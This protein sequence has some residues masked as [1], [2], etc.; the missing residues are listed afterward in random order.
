MGNCGIILCKEFC[1]LRDAYT[2]KREWFVTIVRRILLLCMVLAGLYFW[3]R[4]K[5]LNQIIGFQPMR[6][7]VD[8]DLYMNFGETQ[9]ERPAGSPDGTVTE[10]IGVASF[11]REDGQANFGSVGSPYWYVEDKIVV[12]YNKYYLFKQS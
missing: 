8:G 11:P 5:M 1:F 10:I 2:M 9:Q 4:Q 7:M 6:I 3:H 12:E